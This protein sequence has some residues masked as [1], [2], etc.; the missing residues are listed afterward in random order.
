MD[1]QPT[2]YAYSQE[3]FSEFYD[4]MVAHLPAEFEVGADVNYYLQILEPLLSGNPAP[5]VIRFLD[6]CTG[7]GRVISGFFDKLPKRSVG[8]PVIKIVGVDH[9]EAMLRAA[10]NQV[11]I[12]SD[13][14]VELRWHQASLSQLHVGDFIGQTHLVVISA[15]SF[16]HLI[17][18]EDRRSTLLA[19]KD[20]L[21]PNG[22]GFLVLDLFPD[23]VVTGPFEIGQEEQIGTDFV[24]KPVKRVTEES[25]NGEFVATDSFEISKLGKPVGTMSWSLRTVEHS[26]FRE[27]VEECGLVVVGED[28]GFSG[29]YRKGEGLVTSGEKTTG[30]RVFVLSTQV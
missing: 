2:D 15:G 9:S 24:K 3:C 22:G 6:L 30:G 10:R 26:R 12:P 8:Q 18:D 28:T 13:Q 1:H 21:I 19:I 4:H 20:H 25:S 11:K 7:T 16:H 29:K 14:S 5:P 17:T 27:L 23:E